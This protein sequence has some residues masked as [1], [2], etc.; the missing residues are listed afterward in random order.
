L[1]E[2]AFTEPQAR[3]F[4]KRLAELG[5]VEGRNLSIE[6]HH[7]GGRL[8]RLP[9]VSAALAKVP[10]D[11]YFGSGGEASLSALRQADRQTPIVFVAVDF[12]PISTGDVASLSRPGG[13]VTGVTALQST[14]PAKRLE[15]MKEMLPGMRKLAVIANDETTTQL[16]LVQGTARRLE[17]PIHVVDLK[18]PPFNYA[19]GFA[20]AARAGVDALFVLGSGLFVPDRATIVKKA[21][22]AR[23]PTMFHNA[24]W[25]DA[26]GLA[27][28]GFNFPSMWRRG[29]ELLVEVLRGRKPADIPMEQPTNYELVFNLKTA[30]ALGVKIP[31]A[32]LL[33][34]DRVI[35]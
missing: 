5:L 28:Y 35:E 31:P 23:L 9:A 2:Q 13:R 7:P 4:A 34:A 29:A 18:R 20:E 10:C 14:L 3:A 11:A 19:A 32:L 27:S 1:S 33:R 25:A 15:L 26:G 22:E 6:R 24:Q 30:K 16:L 12:D 21:L 17:L 8:E